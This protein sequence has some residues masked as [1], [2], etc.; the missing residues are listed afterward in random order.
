MSAVHG[1]LLRLMLFGLHGGRIDLFERGDRPRLR[2]GGGEQHK[3]DNAYCVQ[4]DR[5]IEDR[6]P[7]LSDVGEVRH[8][9][10]DDDRRDYAI[11]TGEHIGQTENCT[12][13]ITSEFANDRCITATLKT[14]S[15][16]LVGKQRRERISWICLVG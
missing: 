14:M 4:N 12:G 7:G 15:V 6:V 13:E 16:C 5:Q 8:E 9:N 11:E 2:F 10:A 1:R 3:H